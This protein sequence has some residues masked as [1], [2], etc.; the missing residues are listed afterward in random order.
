MDEESEENLF[1]LNRAQALK[2]Q[3]QLMAGLKGH[4]L[5]VDDLL[6]DPNLL[7]GNNGVT[8]DISSI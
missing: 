6:A 3:E 5:S 4:G 8:Y 1:R 2:Y 7:V